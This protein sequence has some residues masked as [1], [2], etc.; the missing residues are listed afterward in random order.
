MD[1][2]HGKLLRLLEFV[3]AQGVMHILL[4]VTA[5]GYFLKD[6]ECAEWM[7]EIFLCIF[8]VHREIFLKAVIT[9]RMCRN[10]GAHQFASVSPT[11]ALY[12][13][14]SN[15]KD[16]FFASPSTLCNVITWATVVSHGN[17]I[18]TKYG[19][20]YKPEKVVNT[21]KRKQKCGRE[22]FNKC[23]PQTWCDN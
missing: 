5:L 3:C 9:R 14:N 19:I 22:T 20:P 4:T 10:F 1:T 7:S 8:M 11:L 2:K 13:T 6:H 16:K 12:H 21:W 15:Q 23:S 17:L 18:Q